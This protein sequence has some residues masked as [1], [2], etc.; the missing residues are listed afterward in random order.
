MMYNNFI[1][2]RH[3]LSLTLSLTIALFLAWFRKSLRLYH[4]VDHLHTKKSYLNEIKQHNATTTT[5]S[6]NIILILADDLGYSDLTSHGS[7][8]IHT[9]HLDQL[10]STGILHTQFT[11][12][13][14][15]CTPS[16][17]SFL[18]G[19]YPPR[20][21]VAGIV[22]FPPQHPISYITNSLLGYP[23]G[24]LPDELTIADVLK[25]IGYK[26][27]YIGKWH[28]GA[29]QGHLPRDFGYESYYGS[30]Y[31]NDMSPFDLWS[32]ET[33]DVTHSHINQSLVTTIYSLKIINLLATHPKNKPF[34]LTYAPNAPHAPLYSSRHGQSMGGLY[35]DVVEEM[36]ASV[37]VLMKKL[38]EMEVVENTLIMFSSDN[39]PWFE[40]DAGNRRGRKATSFSGGYRVPLIVSWPMKRTKGIIIDSPVQNVDVF[41]TILSICNVKLPMDRMIDGVDQSLLWFGSEKEKIKAREKKNEKDKENE[42]ERMLPYFVQ[43]SLVAARF[44]ERWKL[45]LSH[46]I[47]VSEII[48]RR[49][50]A[51]E[52]EIEKKKK[53]M[54]LTDMS[55]DERESYDVSNKY[56]L[57]GERLYNKVMEWNIDLVSNPRGWLVL[58]E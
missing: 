15:V 21:G 58:E 30:L 2:F 32:N 42:N 29:V 8:S 7:K 23:Q 20:T 49:P 3:T 22:L 28:L 16:R 6:P 10:A 11:T 44:G 13:A 48:R 55:I 1:S 41:R 26:T 51:I 14:S 57:I 39:G 5:T 53:W 25:S 17:A 19:R 24:L 33:I 35:G 56:F 4:T 45:H 52:E 50:M 38:T 36:D 40:G 54:W 12:T 9:P 34:F 37:G 31:S 43:N 46:M 18:T 47:D 27:Y